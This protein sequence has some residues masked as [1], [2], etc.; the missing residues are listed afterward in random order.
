MG[1]FLPV[2]SVTLPLFWPITSNPHSC[3]CSPGS[4]GTFTWAFIRSTPTVQCLL[5]MICQLCYTLCTDIYW[6]VSLKRM[7]VCS[8]MSLD[9]SDQYNSKPTLLNLMPNPLI[10]W[11][12]FHWNGLAVLRSQQLYYFPAKVITADVT[13][14]NWEVGNCQIIRNKKRN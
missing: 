6:Q 12:V 7:W 10:R 1:E 11:I 13:W 3:L 2:C 14:V 5:K 9:G 4:L 8:Q